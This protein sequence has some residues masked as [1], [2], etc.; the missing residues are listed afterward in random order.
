MKA[1]EIKNLRKSYKT[2]FWGKKIP[3]LESLSFDVEAGKVTGFLGANGAGKSTSIKCMLGL[4]LKDSGEVNFFDEGPLSLKSM[5]RIGFLPERPFF[6]EYLKGVEFLEFYGKLSGMKKDSELLKRI[7]ELLELVG[8]SHAKDKH[9]REYS[10]GML[11]RI[12]IAQSIIH[13]PDLIIFDEPM[14][15]LDP[16]GRFEVGQI[17]RNIASQ[18]K[19]VFFSSHLLHDVER[20]SEN[21]IVLKKG[22]LMYQ[23]EMAPLLADVSSKFEMNYLLDGK[24]FSILIEDTEKLQI[25]L[26]ELRN[27]K[28]TILE[29][30][31]AEASLETAYVKLNQ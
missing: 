5:Q 29:V 3:A 30:S 31:Q 11:Q 21:L 9:L 2:E 23:G 10:K 25:Q 12:G 17:L 20:L 6:Y 7:D 15:G 14:S 19:T 8:L 26:D 22:E 1:I 18:G 4:L 24:K 27:K 13:D 16:D 28:A